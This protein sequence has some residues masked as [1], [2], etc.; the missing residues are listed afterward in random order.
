MCSTDSNLKD[1]L[2]PVRAGVIQSLSILWHIHVELGY[3][4]FQVL[5]QFCNLNSQ[6]HQMVRIASMRSLP[7]QLY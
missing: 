2:H 7:Y 3:T 5:I 6:L 1:E 4:F